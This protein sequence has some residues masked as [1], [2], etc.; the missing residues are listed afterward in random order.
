MIIKIAGEIGWNVT[1]EDVTAKLDEATGDVSLLVDSVGGDVFVGA[2]IHQAIKSYNRG[3]V[4]AV[5]QGLA[6]S[7]ASYIV[8]AADEIHIFD[9]STY[10][11]H[12]ARVSVFAGT[13]KELNSK[14]A[15]VDGINNLYLDAYTKKTG[16]S[17][18]DVAVLM[19]AETYFFGDAILDNG[20]ADKIIE[21]GIAANT[22]K[23]LV[24]ARN[25]VT[26]CKNN[27]KARPADA[28]PKAAIIE[29]N[30]FALEVNKIMEKI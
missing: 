28:I 17:R 8:L 20:F 5:V 2:A 21:D 18:E 13:A 4:T 24:D 29:P 12:E 1:T 14:A 15:A 9:N 27:C 26:A 23:T 19:D 7:A 10:M 3:K 30:K 25:R 11:I 16:M 6:A 22:G